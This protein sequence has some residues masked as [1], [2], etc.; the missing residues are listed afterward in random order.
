VPLLKPFS[1]EFAFNRIQNVAA[2][3]EF[4]GIWFETL[5]NVRG[6]SLTEDTKSYR[7]MNTVIGTFRDNIVHSN[8]NMGIQLYAPGWRPSER[9]VLE[10]NVI[11]RNVWNGWFIHGNINVTLRGGLVADSH[12]NVRNFEAILT[13]IEDMSIVGTSASFRN[14]L[15]KTNTRWFCSSPH[16]SLLGVDLHPTALLTGEDDLY[17]T[18]LTNL[19]F[20]RYGVEDT[21][22]VKESAAM[23]MSVQHIT[24]HYDTPNKL[25]GLNFLG[26]DFTKISTCHAQST[27]NIRNI[28]I[29]DAD[30][31]SSGISPGFFVSDNDAMTTFASLSASRCA[32]LPTFECL[33]FCAG[34]CLRQ[35]SLLVNNADTFESMQMTITSTQYPGVSVVVPWT[36]YTSR[37]ASHID[38]SIISNR[39][40]AVLPAGDFTVS[41]QDIATGE[42]RWPDFV[43]EYWEGTP[44]CAPFLSDIQVVKPDP[45]PE[46]CTELIQSG[47][48]ENGSLGKWQQFYVDIELTSNITSNGSQYALMATNR[49]NVGHTINTF[50][51]LT[52]FAP[53]VFYE[54]KAL[55][56]LEVDGAEVDCSPSIINDCPL[57]LLRFRGFDSETKATPHISLHAVGVIQSEQK[58]DYGFYEMNGIVEISESDIQNA[59]RAQITFNGP[60]DIDYIIDDVS[61]TLTEAPPSAAPSSYPTMFPSVSPTDSPTMDPA[62]FCQNLIPGNVDAEGPG[63]GTSPFLKTFSN[64]E[65]AIAE[66][67]NAN[68]SI[69]HYF[70]LK[71]RRGWYDGIYVEA[72]ASRCLEAD[73]SPYSI[74]FRFRSHTEA[75]AV[76]ARVRVNY[77]STDGT[78]QWLVRDK[79]VSF[80]ERIVL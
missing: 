31:S 70:S 78:W 4:S 51:D 69:N 30:G 75:D 37:F 3:S 71:G 36:K 33:T 42:P 17:G 63:V 24:R 55:I 52:C 2:G 34:S 9:S 32:P 77:I 53:G 20:S 21:G 45:T 49:K 39:F 29:E 66:E 40:S 47:D 50:V 14:V 62:E 74:T 1:A 48:F 6:P 56:R 58:T 27:A 15:S 57:A 54:F 67:G 18:K 11:F 41:F 26:A 60:P 10:G 25:S 8:K 59:S 5:G 7:P 76:A 16:G 23:F 68:V 64:S 13:N 22:C 72:A 65:L 38:F 73:G 46:R 28:Y 79:N 12:K 35:V 43:E 19:T 44:D 61:F 80:D